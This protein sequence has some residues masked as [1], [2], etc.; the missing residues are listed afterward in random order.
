MPFNTPIDTSGEKEDTGITIPDPF[1]PVG[2]DKA[3]GSHD[4]SRAT[5]LNADLE[6][7]ADSGPVRSVVGVKWYLAYASILSTVLLFAIDGTIV[8]DI[9]P[10]II[11][12][13]GEVDKLSWI[14]VALSLGTVAILPHGKA[15]TMFNVKWYFI[16]MVL[17]FEVGSAIC[18]AAPT[19]DVLIFGRFVQGFFGCGVYAGGLTSVAMS[20]TNNER[21]LYFSGIVVVYGI[22]SV[23]GPVIGGAFA[24]SSATWKWSFYINLVVAA[25]FAPAMIF[26]LP[27]INPVD[28]PFWKKVK[29]Q[30]WLGIVIFLAGT[31]CY[32]MALTFGGSYYIFSSGSEIALWVMT[33][34]FL[35]TFVLV[36]IYHPGV[37]KESRLYPGHFAK[38]LELVILQ[39]QMFVIAG[40]MNTAIYYTPLIFQ[41][42]RGDG[43]LEAGVRLLPLMSMVVFFSILNGALMPKLG[44]YIPWYI[45]GS[46][47][48]LAG[49]TLMFLTDS[50]TSNSAIYGF[51]ALIGMGVGSI[52]TASVAVAQALVDT[53][54]AGNAVGAMV[55]AQNIGAITFLGISGTLYNNIGA[56]KLGQILPG[57]SR[58]ELLQLIT[59]THSAAFQGLSQTVQQ[60]VIDQVALAISNVFAIILAGSALAFISSLF[61][62]RHKL[63]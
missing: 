7:E 46:A 35:I 27:S 54:D 16:S 4:S 60:S 10:A 25:I 11:D 44:Y 30:D 29:T 17:G 21:P 43:A 19:M 41:F 40:T 37:S 5:A 42:T 23:I 33:A 12:T 2:T 56:E 61:L 34:I 8:A 55:G 3:N 20:T 15:L 14:A 39:F 57:R 45:F 6:D 26:C 24:Q 63:Y 47:A 49:S 50:K 9:Q 36:T 62:G 13:F 28:L 53:S 38:R 52:L 51:T 32:A 1:H 48:T 58:P 59:G 22:G 31:A 18:G